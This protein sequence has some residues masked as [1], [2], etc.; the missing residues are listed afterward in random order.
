M[1]QSFLHE[2]TVNPITDMPRVRANHRHYQM[3]STEKKLKKCQL[4]SVL[5]AYKRLLKVH[6]L[7]VF[8]FVSCQPTVLGA[9]ISLI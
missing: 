6:Y 3:D 4:G 9:S 8:V 5:L 7:E 2:V 1:E